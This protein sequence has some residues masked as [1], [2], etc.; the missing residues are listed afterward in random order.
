MAQKGSRS[1][2]ATWF[3]HFAWMTNVQLNWLQSIATLIRANA[4][5]IATITVVT[6]NE[7]TVALITTKCAVLCKI[8]RLATK[9][10]ADSLES[11]TETFQNVVIQTNWIVFHLEITQPPNWI[12][13][14]FLCRMH[15]FSLL[16]GSL[17]SVQKDLLITQ[18][19]YIEIHD[20]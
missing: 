12:Y 8:Y 4:Q 11:S 20:E 18:H 6:F 2:T 3:Q 5:N 14:H 17:R 13:V 19:I 1:T 9:L 16:M 15:A 10:L 7:S